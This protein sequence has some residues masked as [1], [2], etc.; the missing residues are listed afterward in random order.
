MG[1]QTIGFMEYKRVVPIARDVNFITSDVAAVRS[2][3]GKSG[4]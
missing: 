4:R 3:R 1:P 2:N